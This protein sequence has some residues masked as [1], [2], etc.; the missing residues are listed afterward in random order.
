MKP[1]MSTGLWFL[2]PRPNAIKLFRDILDWLVMPLI[3]GWQPWDQAVVN[4]VR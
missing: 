4:E 3:P 2:Y 1:C